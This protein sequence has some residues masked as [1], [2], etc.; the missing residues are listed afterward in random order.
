MS[1]DHNDGFDTDL[2]ESLLPY[3][4]WLEEAYKHVMCSALSHVSEHGL[5]GEHHFYLTF[6][7]NAPGVNIPSRLLA[8]YPHEMTI[9]LQ[10]QFANL[11]VNQDRTQ[12]N[13]TLSFGG[14]PSPLLIPTSAVVAF[15]DPHMHVAFRFS[16]PAPQDAEVEDENKATEESVQET[17]PGDAEV[18]SLAAFRKRPPN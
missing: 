16:E 10:H 14:V 6:R 18:V 1:D 13:V 9:V 7:T 5:P 4:L 17:P 15:A 11:S 2:P 3:D 8:Q 12:I